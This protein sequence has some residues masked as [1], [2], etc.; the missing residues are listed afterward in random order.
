[1]YAYVR[2]EMMHVAVADTGIGIAPG[3]QRRIF[4]RFFREESTLT[5]EVTGTGLGLA[6]T[7]S[8]IQLHGGDI[9]LDS[10]LGEGSIFTFTM[11][12]AEGEPTDD[13][14]TPPDDWL[15]EKPRA[16]TIL[17]VEDD[18][19][20]ANLMCMTLGHEGFQ[21]KHAASGEE[22]VQIAQEQVP[23]LISLDIR[24]PDINGFEVLR[25]LRAQS[26]TADIPVFVVSVIS[27]EAQ[28]MRFGA[29][30]YLTKPIDEKKL[31]R[32][33]ERTLKQNDDTI[34]IVD[35]NQETL[36]KLRLALHSQGLHV[37][38]ANEG[39]Q[40]LK[41]AQ[42]SHPALM[43]LGLSLP[44]MDGYQILEHL[45]RDPETSDIPVVVTARQIAGPGMATKW[46]E[47]DAL[48]LL[49]QPLSADEL[50]AKLSHLVYNGNGVRK[51]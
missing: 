40:A 49:S 21:V 9:F 26:K 15:T 29:V 46:E 25:Q 14:G 3:N 17:V 12:L 1:V 50:A 41:L 34:L 8:L 7:V 5:E 51:E 20:V 16:F 38:T 36:N 35:E 10:E 39:M 4:E 37:Q 13:V 45:K 27:D 43:V 2:D 47:L 24:L 23:D 31:I 48:Q 32:V 22:A 18:P 33:T 30:D 28:G 42:T 44:D 19:D 6:I 11:P